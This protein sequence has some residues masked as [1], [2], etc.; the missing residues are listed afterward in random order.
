MEL[1]HD[2]FDSQNQCEEI[3]NTDP[4]EYDEVQR[5]MAEDE[6]DPD[7]WSGYDDWSRELEE[8]DAWAGAVPVET[9]NGQ[10]LVKPQCKRTGLH[11]NCTVYA[12]KRAV[13][14]EGIEV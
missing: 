5:L 11:R 2:S 1:Y 4:A 9:P 6:P 14:L 12:C 3:Y 8:S 13:R 7:G 10:I